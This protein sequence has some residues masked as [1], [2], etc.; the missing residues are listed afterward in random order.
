MG[1]PMAA[2]LLDGGHPL[3]C[4]TRTRSKA[5]DLV[6]RG[7]RWA[8]SPAAAAREADVVLLCL[9]D[10]PDVEAVVTGQQGILSAAR[11]DLVVIDHS[12]ISPTA[13][14]K[15]AQALSAKGAFLLDAPISGGDVGARNATLSIMV[16]GDAAALARVQPVLQKL[17]KT[18]THCGPSGSGQ[19]TKLVNQI[20]VS[21]TNLATCEAMTFAQTLGLDPTKTIAAVGGGAA[22][23][24]QLLNLGP[25]MVAGDFRPGFMIDLQQKDLRLVLQAASE[26]GLNL[27]ASAMVHQLFAEAQ[28]DGH[29]RDGTQALYAAVQKAARS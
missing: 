8:D 1:H 7:A 4:H 13:T 28:A 15:M 9:P 24:W 27:R 26:A 18:I 16:G 25:K 11:K 12:T 19:A 21:L 2:H 23:S 17:G 14:R 22:S 3:V 5:D 29:G 6:A 10:T 20:L